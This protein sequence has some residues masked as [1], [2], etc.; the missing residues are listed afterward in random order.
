MIAII[1]RAG[2]IHFVGIG[3][4]GMS[5]LAK[6]ALQA[7]CPVTGSDLKNSEATAALR[8]LGARIYRGHDAAHLEGDV[9]LVV[10]SSAVAEDNP[11][12]VE[13]RKRN[14]EIISRG[15]YLARLMQAYEGIA[16]AGAHGKT[17]TTAMIASV[18]S[19][20]G[21]NPT[22]AVGG[23]LV[24]EGTNAWL[25]NGRYLVAEADES[26]GSFLLLRPKV[27]VVTNVENDHLDYYGGLE[28]LKEAFRRFIDRTD[29]QG[30]VVRCADDPFLAGLDTGAL[31]SVTYGWQQ[32][33]LY[34]ADLI[35]LGGLGSKSTVYEGKEPLGTLVLAVPGRHNVTNALAAVAVGRWFGLSF[36]TIAAAL[37]RYAG[38][39]RRFELLGEAAGRLVVDDYA[40]HPTEIRAALAT[41]RQLGRRMVVVFQP[42]RYTRTARLYREFGAS[43][44][45][46]D[47]VIV[48]EIYPAGEAPLPGVDAQLI[49][50]EIRRRR[51]PPVYYQPVAEELPAFVASLS[52]P[53]DVILTVGAG[54]IRQA[55]TQLLALYG[56]GGQ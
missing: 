28:Q 26:D 55:G 47:L 40:H 11:E 20:A 29:P 37:A 53:G 2:K 13:A 56:Q 31:K 45:A 3:G 4:S 9:A 34:R 25:G 41:A 22:V 5:A 27:S 49:V 6:I 24:R 21:L 30:L 36:E 23:R 42:H 17:T 46:A 39:A 16:V 38:V 7:G 51:H 10:Y 32:E 15:A 44:D 52:R 35:E 33:A 12:L 43:F 8:A 1:D 14:L 19:H 50:E 54:D 48:T 18:L